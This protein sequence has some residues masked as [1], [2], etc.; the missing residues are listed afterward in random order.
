MSHLQDAVHVD[1][2]E[3]TRL[4]PE[5]QENMTICPKA[6][7]SNFTN[8]LTSSPGSAH[9]ITRSRGMAFFKQITITYP[10]PISYRAALEK[11][12]QSLFHVEA[13]GGGGGGGMEV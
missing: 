6:S 10:N 9:L 1:A 4:Y 5:L 8:P 7:P 3:P 11:I 12:R 13:H 2:D